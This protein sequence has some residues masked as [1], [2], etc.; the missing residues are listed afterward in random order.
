MDNVKVLLADDHEMIRQGLRTLLL[1]RPGTEIVAEAKDGRSAVR[2]AKQFSP[3]I[4]I[5][6]IN[7]PDLNGID[8]TRQIK[9]DGKG[10]KVI[11][12]SGHTDRRFTSEMMNAGASGYVVKESAFEEL[13]QAM[14][15]VAHDKIYISPRVTEPGRTLDPGLLTARERQVLELT[16]QGM[17]MKEVA[18]QLKVSV[19]TIETHR[20]HLMEKLDLHSVAELTKYALREGMTALNN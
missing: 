2:L 4:V 20:K 1:N 8:A 15:A 10:T 12:L 6:D 14:S 16:A 17:S 5:M 11:A 3:D 7:M 19:K 9:S 13:A 18:A